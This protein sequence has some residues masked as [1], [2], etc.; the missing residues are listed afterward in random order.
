MDNRNLFYTLPTE[1]ERY[2]YEYDPT[3][4]L[5]YDATMLQLRSFIGISIIHFWWIDVMTDNQLDRHLKRTARRHTKQVLKDLCRFRK[6]RLP[7]HITKWRLCVMLF[8]DCSTD[9]RLTFIAESVL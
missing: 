1:I 5:K 8:A 2:I 6:I 7:R 4:K 9:S 3:Y